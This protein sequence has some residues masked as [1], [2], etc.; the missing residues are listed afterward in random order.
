M[1]SLR[2]RG[3]RGMAVVTSDAHSIGNLFELLQG[4]IGSL[5]A[6]LVVSGIML[7]TSPLPPLRPCNKPGS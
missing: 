7:M 6:F 1:R 5:V 4:F 2:D 3:L